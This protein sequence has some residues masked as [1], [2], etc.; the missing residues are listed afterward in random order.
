[1][2]KEHYAVKTDVVR[3]DGKPNKAMVDRTGLGDNPQA[4]PFALF[5]YFTAVCGSCCRVKE[6]I[7]EDEALLGRKNG[8]LTSSSLKENEV[9]VPFAG[10]LFGEEEALLLGRGKKEAEQK[11]ELALQK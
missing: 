6:G 7:A 8:G 10:E 11:R 2:A 3:P 9:G 4:H 1:M 5:G